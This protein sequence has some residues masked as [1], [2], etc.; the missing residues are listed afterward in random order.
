MNKRGLG[1][2]IIWDKNFRCDP[3]SRWKR[4][5]RE[6]SEVI[7]GVGGE[8]INVDSSSMCVE[9]LRLKTQC[10]EQDL[11]PFKS[12]EEKKSQRKLSLPKAGMK[13]LQWLTVTFF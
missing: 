8:D 5:A 3:Y 7:T 1:K 9:N 11:Q 2:L 13:N 10:I 4:G 6:R 12:L